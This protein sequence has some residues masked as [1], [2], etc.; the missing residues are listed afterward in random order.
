[1]RDR[2]AALHLVAELAV[3]GLDHIALTPED[4]ADVYEGLS[5][6]L[7]KNESEAARYAATCIRECQRAQQDF[8][9]ALAANKG[10]A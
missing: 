10:A 8:L 3:A 2:T 5:A 9:F 4:R 7:A 1:M 6:F